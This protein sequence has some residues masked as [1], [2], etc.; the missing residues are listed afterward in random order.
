M[1]DHLDLGCAPSDEDCAQ[2][3]KDDY[4]PRARRECRASIALL[5]RTMG[6]EPAGARLVIKSNPHDLGT[7][8]SFVCYFDDSQQ[9]AVDYAYR[10]ESDA[11]TNWDK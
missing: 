11:P 7:N 5:R 1:R 2:V 10:C 6:N 9:A 3:G 4:R 8:L